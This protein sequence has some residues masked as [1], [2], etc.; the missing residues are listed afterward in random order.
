VG[1]VAGDAVA[2]ALRIDGGEFLDR[3]LVLLEV[4][5]ERLRVS[6]EEDVP[7]LLDVVRLDGHV[8]NRC[9]DGR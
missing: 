1:D 4:V 6:L 8:R 7:R 5:G 9:P 3:L 2:H